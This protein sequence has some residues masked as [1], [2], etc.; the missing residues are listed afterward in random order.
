[1]HTRTHKNKFYFI[2]RFPERDL[3]LKRHHILDV[4]VT[5]QPEWGSEAWSG[6]TALGME[7]NPIADDIF[8][9]DTD[10]D[11]CRWWW[12]Y[13]RGTFKLHTR[14]DVEASCFQFRFI[15]LSK[16]ANKAQVRLA[17]VMQVLTFNIS[18]EPKIRLKMKFLR[19][20]ASHDH[21]FGASSSSNFST[22]SLLSPIPIATAKSRAARVRRAIK[23]AN[24]APHGKRE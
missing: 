17:S 24:L 13:E 12:N 22:K 14:H 10:D 15:C 23:V 19:L 18:Q 6:F 21:R 8:T 11:D 3:E 1:M 9:A 16:T 7:Q 5:S 4:V 20:Q 2:F